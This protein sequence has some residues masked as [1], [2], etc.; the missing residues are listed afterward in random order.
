[1]WATEGQHTVDRPS[2]R[3]PELETCRAEL[4]MCR[5]ELALCREDLTACRE[6]H[7]ST[8]KASWSGV[9]VSGRPVETSRRRDSAKPGAWSTRADWV[10][11]A[12]CP[13]AHSSVP[14]AGRTI[15]R[16]WTS[17]SS[18]ER[19]APH[20][21][22]TWPLCEATCPAGELTLPGVMHDL[23]RCRT[24]RVVDSNGV[25]RRDSLAYSPARRLG[26]TPRRPRTRTTAHAFPLSQSFS[27]APSS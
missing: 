5:D 15:P 17:C 25:D 1:M 11:N 8:T 27:E 4:E 26:V 10:M 23:S 20:P 19:I 21:S 13:H 16:P 3:S 22:P 18:A 14:F 9:E 6:D 24:Q 12:A 7:A 2:R